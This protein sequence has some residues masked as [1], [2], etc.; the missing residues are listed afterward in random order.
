MRNLPELKYRLRTN[1]WGEKE[2]GDEPDVTADA[3]VLFKLFNYLYSLLEVRN[4]RHQ[5]TPFELYADPV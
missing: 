4:T 3:P 1:G 2:D 5:F